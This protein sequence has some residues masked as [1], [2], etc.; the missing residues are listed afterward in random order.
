MP[1]L[2]PVWL[3]QIC[4]AAVAEPGRIVMTRAKTAASAVATVLPMKNRVRP[5]LRP[6]G[7]AG[8]SFTCVLPPREGL[9]GSRVGEA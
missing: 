6:A 1:P 4:V 8:A 2:L 9:P 3:E 7:G 5:R